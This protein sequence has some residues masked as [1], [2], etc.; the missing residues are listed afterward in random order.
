MRGV[1]DAD[2]MRQSVGGFGEVQFDLT[3]RCSDVNAGL[4]SVGA[5]LAR[6]RCVAQVRSVAVRLNS[7]G[8]S[9]IGPLET[10]F[11]NDERPKRRRTRSPL[12]NW[13]K[14][15]SALQFETACAL[16]RHA[17][18]LARHDQHVL[19]GLEIA[20]LNLA[21]RDVDLR[22]AP[23]N[24]NSKLGALHHSGKV[25]RFDFKMLDVAFLDFERD[26]A[27]LLRDCGRESS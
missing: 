17:R 21:T 12:L 27:G 13:I 16:C 25:R 14:R 23:V 20:H 2:C 18:R 4:C 19:P 6:S 1:R 9:V 10:S 3:Q 8:D 24:G 11:G 26:R 15:T 7:R 22:A 5:P